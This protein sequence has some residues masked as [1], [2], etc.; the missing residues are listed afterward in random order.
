MHRLPVLSWSYYIITLTSTLEH[1]QLM[2]QKWRE[3]GEN[4]KEMKITDRA[5]TDRPRE[6]KEIKVQKLDGPI[7]VYL[8]NG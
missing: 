3:E 7:Q 1:C 8:K 6:L 4:L 2:F 5:V